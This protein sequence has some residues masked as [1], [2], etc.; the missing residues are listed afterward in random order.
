M[1]YAA[2]R[3]ETPRPGEIRSPA[4]PAARRKILETGNPGR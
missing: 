4:A 2:I 1:D 3:L